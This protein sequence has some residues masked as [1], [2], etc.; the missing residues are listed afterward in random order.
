[1]LTCQ[2]T[3]KGVFKFYLQKYAPFHSPSRKSE[4]FCE[5]SVNKWFQMKPLNFSH[6]IDH[7]GWPIPKY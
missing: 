2:K 7:I 3:P 1:M 6:N 5:A 4:V